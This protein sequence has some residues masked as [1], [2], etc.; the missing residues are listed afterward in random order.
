MPADM[1]EDKDRKD[2]LRF[3]AFIIPKFA[4]EYKMERRAA[5]RYLKCHGGIDFLFDHWWALHTDNPFW[6]VRS[7]HDVCFQNGGMR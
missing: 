7:M 5:Y 1:E 6:V 2:R 4:E 3:I